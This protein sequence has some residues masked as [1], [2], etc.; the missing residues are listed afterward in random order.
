MLHKYKDYNREV[1]EVF[2]NIGKDSVAD[3]ITQIEHIIRLSNGNFA[4]LVEYP[5]KKGKI[6]S[7]KQLP[8]LELL[9]ADK[10]DRDEEYGLLDAYTPVITVEDNRS[11]VYSHEKAYILIS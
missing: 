8:K 7:T 3:P 11:A 2:E 10:D 4:V 1:C 5:G 9:L 6:V